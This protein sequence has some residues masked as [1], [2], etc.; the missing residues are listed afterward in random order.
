MIRI[1]PGWFVLVAGMLGVFMTT[2]GQTVGVSVFIDPIVADLDLPRERVLLLYSMGTLLGILPAPYIGRLVDRYG[3]RNAIGVVVVALGAAC[4]VVAW[5]HGPW[6][7]GVAFTVLRG[8]A[9]GGLSLVSGQMINLWFDRYRGR[10]NAI[11]MMGLAVGGL[12]VPGVAEQ[13]TQAYGWRTS[14]LVLGVAVVAIMLPLGLLLFRNRPQ[15]Y[16]LLPDFGR[17]ASAKETLAITGSSLAEARRTLMFWYLLAIGILANAVGTALLLDHV[18]VL[19]AAGLARAAAIALLGVVTVSQVICV[20]GGGVLVDRYGTK[21]VGMLGLA[22]LALTVSCVM[23][24]PDFLAGAAYAAALGA[25]LGVLHVVQGAGLAEHFGTR[26]L[27]NLRGVAS[28][29][30][31]FG[32][33]AGPL[34]FAAWP[35][36]VGY[37]IFLVGIAAALVLG[38]VAIPRPFVQS[39]TSKP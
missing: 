6:S 34:P 39:A 20:L 19:Q 38:A 12:V 13:L 36:H 28:M 23:A 26:H 25:G 2:P 33:A 15:T 1:H 17:A 30:G 7:L 27:G 37:M 35:P 11:S 10:A 3:P 31:I 5:A 21:K 29:V 16:G 4:A 9:I 22:L 8:T 32:A 14:Y 18:R 24:V